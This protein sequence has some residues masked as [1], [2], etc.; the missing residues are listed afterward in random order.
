MKYQDDAELSE[1]I[2]AQASRFDAP[3]GLRAR[4]GAELRKAGQDKKEH[5]IDRWLAWQQWTGMGGGFA[6]GVVLAVAVAMFV[7]MPEARDNLAQQIV[8]GHVRSLMVAHL[9]DVVSTDRHTVKPWFSGKLDYSPPVTDLAAEGFK[10]VGGRL[11]YLDERAVAAL[12][13]QHKLHTINVF[14]WPVRDKSGSDLVAMARQGF[15]IISWQQDNM[16]YWAVSDLNAAELKKLAV[17]LGK[18]PV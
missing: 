12:V 7:R 1:L 16:Q 10:L 5:R 4:I 9:A 3:Q 8:Q 11:D 13:Y 15:N 2:K 17:L 18:Q 14:V 6:S